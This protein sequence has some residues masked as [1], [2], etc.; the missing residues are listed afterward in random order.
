MRF[1]RRHI[2][3]ANVAATLALVL[4]MGGGALAATHYLITSTKQISPHVL[5]QLR[6]HRGPQGRTGK[7]GPPGKPGGP[8]G[9]RGPEGPAGPPGL[10]GVQGP[11][12]FTGPKGARGPEGPAG[13]SALSPL[14]S[15]ESESGLYSFNVGSSPSP[16][17]YDAVSFPVL[18]GAAIPK[19]NVEYV[20]AGT[21]TANCPKSGT[22]ARGYLCIYSNF[23]HKEGEAVLPPPTVI[24]N[25]EAGAP[26]EGAGPHGFVLE[27]AG[28]KAAGS[29][30]GVYTVTEK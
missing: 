21:A 28:L 14:P 16:V 5:R 6:G 29:D 9:R 19:S 18:L 10:V 15:G 7:Q 23:E 20:V 30:L 24:V 2:T 8:R 12:G 4:A 13:A 26:A 17:E 22:A 27:W 11:I 25:I 3:Y 1:A